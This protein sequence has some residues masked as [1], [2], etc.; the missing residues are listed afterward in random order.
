MKRPFDPQMAAMDMLVCP[1]TMLE[2]E[3]NYFKRTMTD[4]NLMDEFEFSKFPMNG[5]DNMGKFYYIVGHRY[6]KGC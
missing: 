5:K 4:L 3:F 1:L 6:K 2:C